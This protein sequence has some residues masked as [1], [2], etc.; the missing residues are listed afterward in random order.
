MPDVPLATGPSV[1]SSAPRPAASVVVPLPLHAP[2]TLRVAAGATLLVLVTFVTPLGTGARTAASLG[3]GADLVPWL[4]SAMS[5]G[6]AVALLPT[7][8]LADDVGRRRVLVGG[9]LVLAAGSLVCAAS[10]DPLAF[11][12]GRLV[13]G[14]GGGAVLACALGVIAHAFPPGPHRGRATGV[15]GASV[16][17]GIAVGGLVTAAI[18]RG[19]SWRGS[20]ALLAGVAVLVAVAAGRLLV[21]SRAAERRRPDVLGALLLGGGLGCLLAALVEGRGGVDAAVAV[22]LVAAVLLLVGFAVQE[23]RTAEPMIDL[24]LFR[25]RPFLAATTGALASGLG[26]TSLAALTP[27]V[28][29]GG[30]GRSLLTASLLVLLFAG[31]SVVAALHVTRLPVRWTGRHLLVG[32]LLG[33]AAGQLLQVGLAA[34]SSP[35][36]L[37][38]GTLVVGICFGVLN[39]TVGREAV[40]SV[41]PESAAMGSGANNTARYVG[42]AIGISLVAVVLSG[43]D[44][45]GTPAGVVAGWSTAAMLTAALSVLGA[46]VIAALRPQRPRATAARA[47]R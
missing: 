37:V 19:D 45:A 3:A 7:G 22:L 41:P 16:G 6:L 8:A 27:T 10:T 46:L 44:P 42:S 33:V 5:L 35:L 18:D 34:D 11:I 47:L 30:L 32:G 13:T 31:S 1:T 43:S 17:A 15:W 40:A 21:E 36:T 20:Y 28:V 2:R 29:Q 25:S 39:A 23:A 9:L 38:P 14:V 12:A 4:L 24:A 26:A